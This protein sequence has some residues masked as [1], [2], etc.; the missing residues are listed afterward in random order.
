MSKLDASDRKQVAAFRKAAREL[1]CKDNEER[2]SA[3]LTA[4]FFSAASL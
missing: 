3:R 1:G 2:V 4:L